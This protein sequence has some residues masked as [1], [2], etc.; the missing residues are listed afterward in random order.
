MHKAYRWYLPVIS[1]VFLISA[2]P[3]INLSALVFVGLVPIFYFTYLSETPLKTA[4]GWGLF[5]AVHAGYITF[6]VFSGFHWLPE[7]W[8]FNTF[9]NVVAA[10]AALFVVC[11]FASY[12]FIADRLRRAFNTKQ[13]LLPLVLLFFSYIGLEFFFSWLYRG[14]NYGS[15]AFATQQAPYF[16]QTIPMSNDFTLSVAA[17]VINVL[18]FLVL[19]MVTKQVQFSS[20][21]FYFGLFAGLASGMYIS[22]LQEPVPATVD[23]ISVALIQDGS[24][25]E[26]TAFGTIV[27]DSFSFPSLEQH[28]ASIAQQQDVDFI[29]YPFAPWSGIIGSSL[30]NTQFDREVITMSDEVFFKWLQKHVPQD[31]IFVT[32]YTAYR[33]GN[34]YN[35]IVYFQ[36][37]KSVSTYTKEHLFPFFDYTPKWA[38]DRGIV[39]LPYDATAG[40]TS[41]PFAYGG[42]SVGSLICSEIGNKDAT[43]EQASKSD[44]LFSLGSETMFEHQIPGEYNALEAQRAAVHYGLP[45]VRSN[46]LGP[47][48]VYDAKG[49][50]LGR[51]EYNQTGVLILDIPVP[52]RLR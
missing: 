27:D 47:S 11:I 4:L 7:T 1:A 44:L 22:P 9:V 10:L 26:Q 45:V 52:D 36:N 17:V 39:S 25:D 21:V 13:S 14:F 30:D 41:T 3:P 48:V 12:F 2:V 42:I 19:L 43:Q 32:W 49:T 38:L 18:L 23:T 35:Q 31:V 46:R 40:T 20:C 28:I 50:L 16:F 34:F 33:N 6:S 24:R 37:G 29:V 51:M 15:L 5:S 8:L